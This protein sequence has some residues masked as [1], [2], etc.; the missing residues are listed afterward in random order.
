MAVETLV[1]ER[2]G[3]GP[4][5]G[6]PL[7]ISKGQYVVQ[8]AVSVREDDYNIKFNY[9]GYTTELLEMKR[10]DKHRHIETA[11]FH[12]GMDEAIVYTIEVDDDC[13]WSIQ[14]SKMLNA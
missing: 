8:F 7:T 10:D 4:F 11:P 3:K 12:L 1:V 9:L 14:I 5:S 13:E 2:T 6:G